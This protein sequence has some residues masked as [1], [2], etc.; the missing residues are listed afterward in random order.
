MEPLLHSGQTLRVAT[1]NILPIHHGDI[2]IYDYTHAVR[3]DINP[4]VKRVV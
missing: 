4:I 2:V 3:D 1:K